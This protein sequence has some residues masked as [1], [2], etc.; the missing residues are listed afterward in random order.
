MPG[1]GPVPRGLTPC[2]GGGAITV[3]QADADRNL[4]FGFL[5]L[6]MDFVSREALLA[7]L[8][9]WVADKSR[10]LGRLFLRQGVLSADRHA[11]L[12]AL[13]GEHLKAHGHDPA[14]SLAALSSLG[15][16][17]RDVE[18]IADADLAAS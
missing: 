18:R 15:P 11:L 9:A 7:A 13:V 8:G 12:E 1:V 6:Q 10:D 17:R 16:V 2:R 14:R 4:L 5:A 3:A